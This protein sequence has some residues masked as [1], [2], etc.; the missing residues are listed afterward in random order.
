MTRKATLYDLK[1]CCTFYE[2]E[3]VDCPLKCLD[4]APDYTTTKEILDETNEALLDW[5]AEHPAKTRQDIFLE[6][7]PETDKNLKGIIDIAPCAL[8]QKHRDIQDNGCNGKTCSECYKDF[9][10]EEIE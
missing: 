7:Y 2:G 4:C 3:C 5:V 6:Q 9:W 1:R 8:S 10:S